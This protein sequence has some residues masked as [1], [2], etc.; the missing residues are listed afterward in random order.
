MTRKIALWALAG[1]IVASGWVAF[2]GAFPPAAR[3]E[4]M[5]SHALLT[6][7]EITAPAALVRHFMLK[8]YWFILMNAF[9]YAL[10][11]L[12]IEL[13]RRHSLRHVPVR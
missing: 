10:I 8:Y 4:L 9:A 2:V 7:I 3:G 12:G 1:F 5:R 13:L 6:F 11:G